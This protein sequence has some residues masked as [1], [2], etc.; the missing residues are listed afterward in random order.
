MTKADESAM[1]A[2]ELGATSAKAV[3]LAS[4]YNTGC[5]FGVDTLE[6]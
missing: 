5:G 4:K 2:M 3:E 1:V 6:F